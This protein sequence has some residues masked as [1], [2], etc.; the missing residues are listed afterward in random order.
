MTRKQ[1]RDAL[2]ELLATASSQV[3]A[4]LLV[5]LAATRPDV[6]RECFDYLKKH[7]SLSDSRK[8]QSE[9]EIL[10]ALWSELDPDLS[11]LDEYGGGDY[12]QADDVASLL[13]QIEQ[14]LSHKKIVAG[15]RQVLLE[16]VLPYIESGNA[17]LDDQLYDVAYATCYDDNDLRLLAEAFEAMD[18]DWQIE[19]ARRIYR[20]LDDRDKYLE[21]RKLKM[22]YGADYYDLASF[23]WKAGEKKQAIQVAE[24]GL[25]RGKGRMDE[26]RQF[27]AQRAKDAGKRDRYLE[28]QFAQT[29]DHLTCDKYKTF[30]K[31]CTSAEWK[32]YEAKILARVKGAWASE[33]LRIRMHRKEYDK[34]VAVLG[35][36][37]YPHTAWNSDYEI[38]TAKRLEQ[39]F[40]EEILKYYLSGLGN[41]KSNA[42][43]KEYARKAQVMTKIRRLLVE[44]LKDKE[45]WRAFAVKVKQDNIK[46]PAFQEEFAKVVPGWRGLK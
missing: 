35:E 24:Q 10:L 22:T 43:R 20:K 30:R 27:L 5:R 14:K 9:G 40:P 31:L 26:L 25:Q 19:H 3:L 15:Y 33:Q 7:V 38:Q 42:I 32:V 11:E 39:R 4:D 34:A 1:K 13:Y 2:A 44:V 17:G 45:R 21:L 28:L 18:G 46:R 16:N 23:Y 12:D 41:M 37:G 29:I 8:N 36:E 6:R